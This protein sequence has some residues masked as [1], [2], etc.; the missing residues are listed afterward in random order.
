MSHHSGIVRKG[1]TERC[2]QQSAKSSWR[3]EFRLKV[4]QLWAYFLPVA[5]GF[6]SELWLM[7]GGQRPALG[8]WS[9]M[10][11]IPPASTSVGTILLQLGHHLEMEESG[12]E[13]STHPCC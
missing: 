13:P 1:D 9:A 12:F 7:A 6:P 4:H 10:S 5:W 11:R 2:R 3:V 8:D